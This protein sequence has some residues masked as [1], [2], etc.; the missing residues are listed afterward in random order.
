M[1]KRMG[2]VSGALGVLT[3]GLFAATGA[4]G[5][6]AASTQGA[7]AP[8]A[9][10]DVGSDVG[11]TRIDSAV[12][13]YQE[14]GGRVK[15]TEPVVSVV[16]NSDSGDVLSLRLTSDTLTG[17]TPNGATPWKQAQTF[18]T[19]AHAPGTTTTVTKASGGST[20]V[21][22][23]GTGTVARQYVV[24][25]NALPVDTGFM[26]QRYALDAG[27]SAQLGEATHLSFGAAGSTE[28]DYRSLSANVGVAHDF[29]QKNTTAS[30]GVSFEQD[31]SNPFFGTPAALTV[32][33]AEVKG[34]AATKTVVSLVTGV[35]QV[36][37]RHWLVQLNYSLGSTDG[38]QADP[39]RII[40]VVDP[41]TGAPL[42][43]LYEGRPKSR[44]RQS[45]YMG[46]KLAL[47]PTVTDLSLRAYH[48]SWGISSFT[49]DLSERVPLTSWLYVEPQARYYSQSAANFFHDYLVGGQPLPSVASSDSRLGQFNATTFGL[50]AGITF[51]TDS[52]FSVARNS[53]LYLQFQDYQQSGHGGSGPVAA[54]A[55]IDKFAGVKAT[56]LIVGYTFAFY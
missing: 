51:R 25:P 53:E 12:L 40:S 19:P 48:D 37:N 42:Q 4:L 15:A 24:A 46:N 29:N 44:L 1:S 9:S 7:K 32:M 5:Q 23:P 2:R 34:P 52:E 18:I 30:L 14:A 11:F 45:L 33:S 28:R 20:L 49:A 35:T 27:Y 43:Y 17:A 50:K 36:V 55:G 13:F 47:G 39:Y 8:P 26:D 31:R 16:F 21:T 56:S 10:D 38:Y 41:S 3:A 6:E 22:I 54:L